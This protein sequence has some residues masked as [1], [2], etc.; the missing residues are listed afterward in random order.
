MPLAASLYCCSSG[1][2]HF[3]QPYASAIHTISETRPAIVQ[4]DAMRATGVS[5]G[6][7]ACTTYQNDSDCNPSATAMGTAN[8][9]D[10]AT[11]ALPPNTNTTAS[12]SPNT[13][14]TARYSNN[15]P[16]CL[17]IGCI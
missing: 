16:R 9:S 5:P 13:T 10:H 15:R 1:N 12:N 2:N 6:G 11:G 3:A 17:K 14:Q 4:I 7:I 8:S